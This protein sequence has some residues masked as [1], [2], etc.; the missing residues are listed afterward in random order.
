MLEQA[1]NSVTVYQPILHLFLIVP[2]TKKSMRE[3]KK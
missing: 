1:E 2:D 3:L